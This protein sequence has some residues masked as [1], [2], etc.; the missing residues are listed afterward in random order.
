MAKQGDEQ[1]IEDIF[2]DYRYDEKSAEVYDLWVLFY[3]QQLQ[4]YCIRAMESSVTAIMPYPGS[5]W[6]DG[7]IETET[8]G[9]PLLTK[10]ALS[11]AKDEATELLKAMN[12]Q[13]EAPTSELVRFFYDYSDEN[14]VV[15]YAD[16]EFDEDDDY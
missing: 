12:Q 13:S 9:L 1:A 10:E 16:D 5:D 2:W 15:S 11:K 3:L 8:L 14:F 4:G 6:V 7:V